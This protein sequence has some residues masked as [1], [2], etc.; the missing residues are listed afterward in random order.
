MNTGSSGSSILASRPLLSWYDN[1]ATCSSPGD[2]CL[3]SAVHSSRGG[4]ES[5]FDDSQRLKTQGAIPAARQGPCNRG[6]SHTSKGVY[7]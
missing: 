7:A 4:A 2:I 1:F 6:P 5:R 3:T